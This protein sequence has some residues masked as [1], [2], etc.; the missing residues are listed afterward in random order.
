MPSASEAEP[1]RLSRDLIVE[2]YLRLV[3]AEGSD[4][5]TLRRLGAELGVDPTAIYRHFK[6]K[7]ELLAVASDRVLG[8]VDA[9]RV[10]PGS[11]R[12]ELRDLLLRVRQV[13]VAHP[14][15][16]QALQLA[17]ASMPNAARLSN[18]VIAL[19]RESGLEDDEAAIA[20][21]GL[22]TM[23]LGMSLFDARATEESVEG[24]RRAYAS[25]SE[26]EFPDLVRSARLLYRDADRAFAYVLDLALDALE[27]RVATAAQP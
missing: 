11:W 8:E 12:D 10:G 16:M 26:E 22:E 24:W 2:A 4:D 3:E 15:A 1:I 20:Y 18:R 13:Y 25:G 6:D 7:D 17:P 19:L 27:A 14:Q 21:D 23:T 5:I 9:G